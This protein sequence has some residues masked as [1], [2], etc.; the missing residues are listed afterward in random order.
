MQKLVRRKRLQNPENSEFCEREKSR[1]SFPCRTGL[2]T[3]SLFQGGVVC[4]VVQHRNSKVLTLPSKRIGIPTRAGHPGV[5]TWRAHIKTRARPQPLRELS[6]CCL[7]PQPRAA[8]HSGCRCQA[9]PYKISKGRTGC[10]LTIAVQSE[11]SKLTPQKSERLIVE[12]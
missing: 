11:L 10:L 8:V 7:R 3:C 4:G 9:L 12:L 6:L 1:P 5:T 2:K